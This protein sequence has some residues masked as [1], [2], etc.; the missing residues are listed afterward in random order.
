M[1]TEDENTKTNLF[2]ARTV[3]Y[4]LRDTAVI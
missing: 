3:S 2:N 1:T 4:N